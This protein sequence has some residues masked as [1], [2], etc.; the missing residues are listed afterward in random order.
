MQLNL[1]VSSMTVRESLYSSSYETKSSLNK[2]STGLHLNKA[3]DDPSG[4]SIADKLRTQASSISQGIEN[5]NSGIALTQIADKAMS[6]QSNI[7]DIIKQKLIQASTATT[8]IK[9]A[10]AI[11]KDI[12]KL[13]EQIDNIGKQTIY[14]GQ[15]LLQLSAGGNHSTGISTFQVGTIASDTIQ[16]DG[17]IAS[18]VSGLGMNFVEGATS[19]GSGTFGVNTATG[20]AKSAQT[21]ARALMNDVDGSLSQLNSWRADIGSTQSQLESSKN[22]LN[23]SVTNLKNAESVI[24]DT[25]YAKESANFSK[26]N[27]IGEA[28]TYALS[29]ANALQNNVLSILR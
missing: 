1:Q 9:G 17:G 27:I 3:S 15:L 23:T 6:E 7:L 10:N 5:I 24:R 11:A 13:L 14:N 19:A 26:N 12:S 4:L 25:D 21:A 16:L 8:S 20:T 22:N 2:I 18:N 29:Q 28:G